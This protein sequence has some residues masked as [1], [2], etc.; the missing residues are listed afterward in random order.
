MLLF[1]EFWAKHYKR[2][3]KWKLLVSP[4]RGTTFNI[5]NYFFKYSPNF[6]FYLSLPNLISSLNFLTNT[7]FRKT[8]KH[9]PPYRQNNNQKYKN[10][11]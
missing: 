8:D 1:L 9:F 2:P 4:I 11:A 10:N 6:N 5:S 7:S 3:Y